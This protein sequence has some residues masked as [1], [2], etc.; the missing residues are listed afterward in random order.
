MLARYWNG[1]ISYH[2][3]NFINLVEFYDV[4]TSAVSLSIVAIQFNIHVQFG[5]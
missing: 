4:H 2:F 1:A 3:K 5:A